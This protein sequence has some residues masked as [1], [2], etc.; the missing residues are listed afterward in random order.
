MNLNPT[1]TIHELITTLAYVND[2][3]ENKKVYHTHR[4]SIL[5]A[6]I[7]KNR[8]SRQKL[9]EIFYAAV[10]HDVGGVGFPHHIIHYLKRNDKNSKNILLSHPIIGAQLVSA[11]PRM[12]GAAKLILDHH[13]WV[14][15]SGYPRGKTERYIPGGAQ[16]I[17]IAD[18][19]D[20]AI[21]MNRFP[22]LDKLKE[23]LSQNINK[24]Y[25]LEL[26]NA[27]I[28]VLG[29]NKL[30]YNLYDVNNVPAIFKEVGDSVGPIK[31]NSRID[32]IGVTLETLAQVI[33]MKHPYTAGHSERVC[34]YAVDIALAMNLKHNEITKIK[35]AGLIHDIGKLRVPRVILDKKTHLSHRELNRVRKHAQFTREIISMVSTLREI[36]PIAAMHHE[37]FDGTG[38]PLGLKGE[39][40]PLG[41]RILNV[42][43]AFD[44]MTSNRPYRKSMSGLAA[45]RELEKNAGTQFDPAIVK[46]T[47]PLFKNLGL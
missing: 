38:Y 19:I 40:I 6:L 13:E 44:A 10:L 18:A 34:R 20:I 26:F 29:E 16:I 47:I 45:C 30:F 23:Y 7:A 36:A 32:A 1:K 25:T 46:E 2:M 17:R 11:I 33:D 3:D 24:E 37:H 22:T 14:N 35:W 9:K 15:G 21:Q 8:V 4:V 41:A 31:I 42:C 12:T 28:K 5:S 39:E 43:D 27:A